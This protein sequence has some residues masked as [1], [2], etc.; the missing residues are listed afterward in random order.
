MDTRTDLTNEFDPTYVETFDNTH[1][2]YT[3]LRNNTPVAHSDKFGGFWAV[4]KYD[5]IIRVQTESVF[6]TSEKNVVPPATRNQGKRPPLHFDPPEHDMYRRPITPVFRKSRM[7][8]LEPDL[9]RFANELLDPLV[10]QSDFDFTKDFAEYFAALSFGL[11]LKLPLEKMMQ[12]RKVQV[13]YYRSQLAMDKPKVEAASDELYAIARELVDDRRENPGDP[14]EDLISALILAGDRGPVISDDMVVASIRQFLSASQAAPG[15]VL[16]S[17]IVHLSRDQELQ[18]RLREDPALIPDAIE[19][20]L[21]LYAPYRV[22]ARA[23]IRDVEIGGRIV[24]AGEPIAMMFP[25]A[26]RDEA[27]FENPH[28]F[29]IDR[30]P[31]KHIA[32]GRGP[33]RCPAAAL[34]R[35]ELRIAME[36]ILEKTASIE[37]AGEVVMSGWLEFG[38]SS[39]PI[40]VT[41]ATSHPR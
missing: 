6:S 19:E 22:F 39:T 32:F 8:A 24:L 30:K 27:I 34:A 18:S 2:Y 3:D 33:H 38:P 16:G 13:E 26:N 15:A 11:I 9:R 17:V 7:D 12:S 28:E 4:F 14:D 37:L 20:F 10:A 35:A 36:A 1:E 5:D 21:R 29:Q 41:P 40:R 31:N 23:P 25:S